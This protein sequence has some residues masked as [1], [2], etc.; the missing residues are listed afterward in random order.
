MA[1]FWQGGGALPD[2][3]TFSVDRILLLLVAPAY[4]LLAW[5]SLQVPGPVEGL[6]P[7][8]LASGLALCAVLV[9]GA[10]ALPAVFAGALLVVTLIPEG[11][12]VVGAVR[13]LLVTAGITMQAWMGAWLA[14]RLLRFP[15]PLD[16]AGSILVFLLLV[17]PLSSLVSASIA[18][19]VLNEFNSIQSFPVWAVWLQWSL[20]DALGMLIMSP[21]LL[22]LF[23]KPGHVWRPRW[24][25]VA[26]PMLAAA[27][28]TLLLFR[29]IDVT[30][31]SRLATSFEREVD[32]LTFQLERR[33]EAQVEILMAL[34][35]F[36]ALDPELSA[37][38]FRQFSTLF[39]ERH[40]GSQNL[41][42]NPR[43]LAAE[44]EA[45]EHMASA[46]HGDDFTILARDE[47]SPDRTRSADTAREHFPIL[48][49]EPVR[50]NR[51]VIGLDP[52]TIPAPRAA[53]EASRRQRLPQASEAF[54]L[55]QEPGEQ[56]GVVV[57]YAIHSNDPSQA[58]QDESVLGL[59][60]GAFRMGDVISTVLDDLASAGMGFCLLDRDALPGN[61]RLVGPAQCDQASWNNVNRH[62]SRELTFAGRR[63][64][65]VFMDHEG[66]Y[67]RSS[68]WPFWTTGLLSLLVISSLGGFLLMVSGQTRRVENL[69]GRRTRELASVTHALSQAQRIAQMGSWELDLSSNELQYSDSLPAVL[70]L[71]TSSKATLEDL[72]LAL[73]PDD[74]P[75]LR[76][77]L[78]E[79]QLSPASRQL[80]CRLSRDHS[81]YIRLIMECDWSGDRPYRL[82][83]TAQDVSESREH[84]REIERLAHYDSLTELPNRFLWMV[85]AESALK[86]ASRYGHQMAVLFMD[87]DQFKTIN[88]SL[89]HAVGDELLIK[90]STRFTAC[91]REEDVLARM[92]G[93]EFVVLLPR[94]RNGT[95]A[96]VVAEKLLNSLDRPVDVSGHELKLSVSIGIARYPDDGSD[97]ATLIQ[98]A[99]TAMYQAKEAGRDNLK[100]FESRM[101]E[102]ARE[103]LYLESGIRRAL[104]RRE[105]ILHYQPQV[106][107]RS[108]RVVG[109]EALVRW[110][111]PD[112]GLL[113]PGTFI[114]A[115]ER[116]GLVVPLG[117]QVF[118]SA[119]IQQ[120]RW[121]EAGW[122]D[123]D[124]SINI[125]ALQFE[126]PD[127]LGFIREILL[128][129]G[130]DPTH[131][132]LELT[133]SALME[134]SEELVD[135]LRTIRDLG[136][137]LSLDDFG[138]G[139]SS[140]SYLKRLPITQIKLD[141][142]FVM[143][144]PDD[145][146][147]AAIAE[148]AI[149]M[150]G[151]LGLDVIAEGVET[152]AQKEFL[153]ERGCHYMQGFLF[154]RP[155][156]A[157][158][159]MILQE[160]D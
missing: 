61:R 139:Y 151:N 157:E 140:L 44:R 135:R 160:L 97:V 4:V 154:H 6:A 45:F 108:G 83:G 117:K 77:V 26:I 52:L 146:E 18:V 147:D 89:G 12:Q 90:L 131:L 40:P 152:E 102:E 104:D 103:R 80:E 156:P 7:A 128:E 22:V 134:L 98:H 92:G 42:F 34:E 43:V 125:S 88:D 46:I 93:D 138:T 96:A 55:T 59:V 56:R 123:L 100:F 37:D 53:I 109:A 110:N 150:A 130:T 36:V 116:S 124:V 129:T 66:F 68:Q 32:T 58:G 24:P 101:N 112:K 69:V 21:I 84:A 121:H 19:T 63:W 31:N 27:I 133:E 143:D 71:D 62:A 113:M 47:T 119:C 120:V 39:L 115:A 5:L 54:T 51:S 65:A 78:H 9:L 91:L 86:S 82:R 50:D 76:E 67:S 13:V 75:H 141:R 81:R 72:V 73:H 28:L 57:Y 155:A 23:G 136:L 16:S 99:D 74:R 3:W 132:K 159:L 158:A 25:M 30:E 126:R 127:F 33:L 60:T 145:P 142:S 149:N 105:F 94:I 148:T 35:R 79:V 15:H 107:V 10:R 85:C 1:G 118:R 87:L 48:F 2:K 49:V 38:R 41:T 137:T 14:R 20:G 8:Y 17:I 64:R 70:A 122:Q 111:H 95:D 106:D 114:P 29:Q 11:I 153:L 144:L